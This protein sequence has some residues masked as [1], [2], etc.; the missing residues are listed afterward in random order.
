MKNI[1]LLFLLCCTSLSFA[2]TDEDYGTTVQV[3]IEGIKN[4]DAQKVFDLFSDELKGTLSIEKLQEI[5]AGNIKEYGTPSEFDFMMDDNGLKRYLVQTDI[6][7][8]MVDVSLSKDLK[9]TKFQIE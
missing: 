1:I 8:F 2:Q 7:S 4:N 6:D 5:I 9:I 3:I